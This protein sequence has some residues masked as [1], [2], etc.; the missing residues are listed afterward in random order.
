[1]VLTVVKGK[2][3]ENSSAIDIIPNQNRHVRLE[4][5]SSSAFG[6][7]SGRGINSLIFA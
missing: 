3:K 7:E 2:S 5:A 4:T 6:M 1:M